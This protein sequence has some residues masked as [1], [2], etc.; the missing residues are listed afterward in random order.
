[1]PV[2]VTDSVRESARLLYLDDVRPKD[3]SAKLGISSQLISVWANRYGWVAAKRKVALIVQQTVERSVTRKLVKA[4]EQSRDALADEAL[5]QAKAFAASPCTSY[6]ELVDTKE[7]K[8][9]ASTFK[10]VVEASSVVF[11]WGNES[12]VR[13]EIGSGLDRLE[14]IEAEVVSSGQ[15][16]ATGGVPNKD[17]Y[18]QTPQ[19]PS[20]T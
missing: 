7:G 19:L 5:S 6:G 1:V 9:R 18:S 12:P 2:I 8:G 16:T 15:D 14:T 3:I 10:T 11:G 4:S 20:S 13:G 17:A